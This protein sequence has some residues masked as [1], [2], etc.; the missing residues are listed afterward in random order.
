MDESSTTINWKENNDHNKGWE[1]ASVDVS[2]RVADENSNN[3]DP[4]A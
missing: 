1:K 3:N 4:P 2:N